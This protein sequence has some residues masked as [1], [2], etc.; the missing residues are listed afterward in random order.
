VVVVAEDTMFVGVD[1]GTVEI[2][3]VVHVCSQVVVG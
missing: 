2:V 3:V 1:D